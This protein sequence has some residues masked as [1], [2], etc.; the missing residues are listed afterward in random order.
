MFQ[1]TGLYDPEIKPVLDKYGSLK[2]A[3]E[4]KKNDPKIDLGDFGEILYKYN[5][6]ENLYEALKTDVG[7]N[8]KCGAY[9]MKFHL[10]ANNGD[11][12]KSL[13]AYNATSAKHSYA[14]KVMSYMDTSK[15]LVK[16]HAYV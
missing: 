8:L 12:R 7:L 15:S 11:I 1:R 2:K 4:A 5:T 14:K 6:P 3:F 9:L 16:L 10:N 13:E